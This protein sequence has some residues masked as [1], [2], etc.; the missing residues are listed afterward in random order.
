MHGAENLQGGDL[1]NDTVTIIG[2]TLDLQDKTVRH[3][4]TPIDRVFMLHIDAKL[5]YDTLRRICATGHSRIP[6]YEEVELTVPMHV[7]IAASE[8]GS[9]DGSQV[10]AM[11]TKKSI[12]GDSLVKTKAKKI[13]GVLLVKH[14]VLLDP[15]GLFILEMKAQH[16]NLRNST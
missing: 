9:G 15:E 16:V 5:D 12:D 10:P 11:A 14:C 7:A 2:A 1:R 8:M 3:S 13:I 4:M 6:V